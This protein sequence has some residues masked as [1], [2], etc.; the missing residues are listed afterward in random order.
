MVKPL[1]AQICDGLILTPA[2]GRFV[3]SEAACQ[4]AQIIGFL[5][6]LQEKIPIAVADFR[7]SIDYLVAPGA[8]LEAGTPIA[9]IRASSKNK[10]NK[11]ESH[12]TI[13]IVSPADGF[14]C[15]ANED[16]TAFK[17]IGQKLHPGDCI[18]ILE[19]MKIRMDI[20]YDGPDGL[21]FAGYKTHMRQSVKKNECIAEAQ[22]P[23]LC[24]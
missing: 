13:A 21:L 23:P 9:R 19:F 20:R 24:E 1:Y 15:C 14:L 4:D 5:L 18:A 7:G 2:V 22:I 3:P 8:W 16:G 10:V 6:R 11:P 12:A 17:Q